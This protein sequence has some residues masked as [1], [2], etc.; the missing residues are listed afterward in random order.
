MAILLAVRQSVSTVQRAARRLDRLA[1]R[2]S[3]GRFPPGIERA[4]RWQRSIPVRC[5][6]MGPARTAVRLCR[7]HGPS[8]TRLWVRHRPR[9]KPVD[10][11]TVSAV[12]GGRIL[13]LDACLHRQSRRTRKDGSPSPEPNAQL[14]CIGAREHLCRLVW[15]SALEQASRT[16]V[17]SA[18]V[19]ERRNSC[20]SKEGRAF[21]EVSAF[22]Q[23]IRGFRFLTR[24]TMQDT[25]AVVGAACVA[26]P[27]MPPP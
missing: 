5:A 15:A 6:T 4:K 21:S 7:F 11:A 24:Y 2:L 8:W 25:Q 19:S 22:S 17:A 23:G 26:R 18:P 1:G 9:R 13:R 10:I 14:Y 16:R 3:G 12:E 20:H 27:T